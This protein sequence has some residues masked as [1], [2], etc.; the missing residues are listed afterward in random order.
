MARKHN[1][2]GRSRR[3]LTP[4]IALEHYLLNCPAWTSL[5]LAARC[6]FLELLRVYD[7]SNNGRL[8]MSA[9]MLDERLPV[10]R[11]TAARALKELQNRGFLEPVRPGGFNVKSGQRRASEWRVTC[12]R[13]D[14]TGALP[15]K[16]F[17]RWQTG[18]IHLAVSSESHSGLTR[19]PAKTVAQQ[20]CRLVAP[21]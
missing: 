8:I 15:A 1:A 3:R 12:Y 5:S 19:E 17:M 11:A 16:T 13:C 7:G 10:S 21:T 18:K 9:R 4:F 2:T 14:V 6:T 20:N